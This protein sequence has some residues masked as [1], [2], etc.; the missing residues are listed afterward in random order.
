M[1]LRQKALTDEDIFPF[2]KD[3]DGKSNL[4]IV[5]LDGDHINPQFLTSEE[6]EHLPP[7][8]LE[9]FTQHQVESD[10]IGLFVT[11]YDDSN[12]PCYGIFV[13]ANHDNEGLDPK[14]T[15][16]AIPENEK[17]V[18]QYLNSNGVGFVARHEFGHFRNPNET[19]ADD[20]AIFKVAEAHRLL[21]G[22][23]DNRV[24]GDDSGYYIVFESKKGIILTNHETA[25]VLV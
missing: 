18:H 8:L 16:P 6:H 2:L 1:F 21:F 17:E 14:N 7:K 15:K 10:V 25:N 20:N 12:Q 5:L 24:N 19:M 11:Y 22:D 23:N 3:Q 4:D 13:A 9:G